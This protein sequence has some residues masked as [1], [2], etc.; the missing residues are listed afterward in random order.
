MLE[1]E[2]VLDQ[3]DSSA[4]FSLMLP[5]SCLGLAVGAEG[6]VCSKNT[7][8]SGLRLELKIAPQVNSVIV[9][10]AGDIKL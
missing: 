9:M 7:K 2:Q 6:A 4:H 10:L 5:S 1:A 3:V 8:L